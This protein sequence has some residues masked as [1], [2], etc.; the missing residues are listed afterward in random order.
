MQLDHEVISRPARLYRRT[1]DLSQGA[2]QFVRAHATIP[3]KWNTKITF[4][5][6]VFTLTDQ[7]PRR[8]GFRNI[9]KCVDELGI[10]VRQTGMDT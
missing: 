5:I 7:L 3:E 2:T 8:V 6:A 10:T 1:P 9:R 4:N